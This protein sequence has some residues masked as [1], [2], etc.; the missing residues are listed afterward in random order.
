[1]FGKRDTVSVLLG[2]AVEETQLCTLEGLGDD[3]R[4]EGAGRKHGRRGVIQQVRDLCNECQADIARLFNIW[5]KKEGV[6][7]CT[8]ST[9]LRKVKCSLRL[10][11]DFSSYGS[12]GPH[13]RMVALVSYKYNSTGQ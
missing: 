7:V 10:E 9:Y 13:T 6:L 2:F 12:H 4:K 1:M 5:M 8:A 3:V 11:V